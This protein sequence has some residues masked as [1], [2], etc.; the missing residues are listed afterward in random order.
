[1]SS[2]VLVVDAAALSHSPVPLTEGGYVGEALVTGRVV[3]SI[4]G[5]C[6]RH[7]SPLLL[8]IAFLGCLLLFIAQLQFFAVYQ[9][10]LMG[11]RLLKER[12]SGCK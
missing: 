1:M 11:E 6:V 12:K 2:L 7:R 3:V 8:L 5:T 10:G 9:Q 4:R